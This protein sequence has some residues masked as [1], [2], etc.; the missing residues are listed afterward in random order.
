MV[1]KIQVSKID[2]IEAPIPSIKDIIAN[3]IHM[4]NHKVKIMSVVENLDSLTYDIIYTIEEGGLIGTDTEN[5]K[6]Q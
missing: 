2:I 5:N 4:P 6:L 1:L 3:K